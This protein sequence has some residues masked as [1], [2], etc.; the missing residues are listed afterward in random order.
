MKR[1]FYHIII[2]CLISTQASA[3]WYWEYPLPQG[4][5]LNDFA[6]MENSNNKPG[7]AIGNKGS[8]LRSD[9]NQHLSWVLMDSIVNVNLYDISVR[10]D[11]KGLIVGD[12]GTILNLNQ[13]YTWSK[14]NSNT[15]YSLHGVTWVNDDKA[16]AVGSDGL[17]LNYEDDLWAPV[18]TGTNYSLNTITFTNDSVGIAA[19]FGGSIMRTDDGGENWNLY[20]PD[21]ALVFNAIHFPSENVGYLVGNK[22]IIVKTENAGLSWN[23][24]SEDTIVFNYNT[25]LFF[26]DTIGYVAGDNGQIFYTRNG[27]KIWSKNLPWINMRI[28]SIFH[29]N[30]NSS[31]GE[32][33]VC[34]ENGIILKSEQWGEWENVTH[35]SFDNLTSLHFYS[36]T[37]GLSFGGYPY[38]NTPVVLRYHNSSANKSDGDPKSLKWEP[39]T[40]NFKN[41]KHYITDVSYPQGNDTIGFIVGRSGGM[42][43]LHRDDSCTQIN[44]G[45]NKSLYSVSVYYKSNSAVAFAA[46]AN[47]TIVK[48]SNLGQHHEVL[49]TDIEDNLFSISMPGVDMDG[50]AVGDN[51]TVL[52]IRNEGNSIFEISSGISSAFYDIAMVSETKGFMVGAYGII[53]KFE[54]INGLFDFNI[55]TSG[56]ST[57][58]I[59]IHFQSPSTGYIVGDN[60]AILKTI[61]GGENW[62]KLYSPTNNHLKGIHF[63]S[64]EVGYLCG[65][66]TTILKTENSGGG[67]I[68]SPGVNEIQNLQLE[69]SL[70]PNPAINIVSMDYNVSEKSNVNISIFDLSGRMITQILSETQSVG[71]QNSTFDVNQLDKGIYLITLQVGSQI[72]AK[73]M[74][75][76]H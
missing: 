32:V 11:S 46:G 6:F 69:F 76:L 45:T 51:G 18:N 72:S 63:L 58:L 25:V 50:Y 33:I 67:F 1:L 66:G 68:P 19:G 14:M 47:G 5:N 23:K 24:I 61:D 26:N 64:D 41:L 44:S 15:F 30:I 40:A 60:G 4:N 52:R 21:S 38:S 59:D 62:L 22:G 28:N 31:A 13:N 56:V 2:L 29:Q 54:I 39:D 70:Y 27:G 74:V 65:Y 7:F 48:I 55:I 10:G 42:Y 20:I 9:D 37:S 49:E 17:I 75:V 57:P 73:K 53:A 34:G 8:I 16:M 3:Q 12:H 35:G 71:K 36:D 43:L